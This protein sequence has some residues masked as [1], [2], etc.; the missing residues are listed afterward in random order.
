MRMG[1]IGAY[2]YNNEDLLVVS[3]IESSLLTHR[4]PRGISAAVAM[5][6]A[7]AYLCNSNGIVYIYNTRNV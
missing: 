2:Y 6:I 3:A 4:D 5:A 7:T 1:P